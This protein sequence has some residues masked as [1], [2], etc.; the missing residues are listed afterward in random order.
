MWVPLIQQLT[1]VSQELLI[2]QYVRFA[3]WEPTPA[4]VVVAS[5]R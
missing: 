4:K 3:T 5:E 1:C 2:A